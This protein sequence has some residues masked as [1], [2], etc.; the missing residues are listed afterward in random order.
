[1][2][3]GTPQSL[4]TVG[5]T[6]GATLVLSNVTFPA[7]VLVVVS[8]VEKST[9]AAAN[10]I[11]DPTNGNY[12]L[13]AVTSDA[14]N[15]GISIQYIWNGAAITNSSLTYTPSNSAHECEMSAFYVTG[16]QTSADPGDININGYANYSSAGTQSPSLASGTPTEAGEL[17]VACIGYSTT[18]TFTEDTTD[19]WAAPP[20]ALIGSTQSIAGG[21]LVNSGAGSKTFAPTLGTSSKVAMVIAAFL[22]AASGDMNSMGVFC[23][24]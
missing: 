11:T 14:A 5:H 13:A 9:S 6:S 16:Q 23:L 18:G 2:A 1:M 4:G 3:W 22:P 19:G 7:N 10:Y 8:V 17:F 15:I 24:P 21:T 12:N 20:T